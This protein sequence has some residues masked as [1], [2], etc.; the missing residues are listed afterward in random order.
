MSSVDTDVSTSISS[1]VYASP[2]WLT[3][4]GRF[5]V[6]FAYP[7][8]WM[9]DSPTVSPR[10]HHFFLLGVSAATPG[11]AWRARNIITRAER[12]G[13]M[14]SAKTDPRASAPPPIRL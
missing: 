6:N 9:S 4:P 13:A 11:F 3:A 5:C 7:A 1:A 8:D 10:V 14:P 2:G 12:Y